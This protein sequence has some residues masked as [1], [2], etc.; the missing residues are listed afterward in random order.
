MA[1]S[2]EHDDFVERLR[3]LRTDPVF[4]PL[5]KG[6]ALNLQPLTEKQIGKIITDKN[7]AGFYLLMAAAQLSRTKLKALMA[8]PSFQVAPKALRKAYALKSRLPR[9]CSFD[10]VVAA[11]SSLRVPDI[12]RKASG[13]VERILRER[14]EEERVP[15]LMSPPIR[16]VPGI[17]TPRERK[18][19]GVYP[20]P[21]SNLPPKL[22]LEIKGIKRV[23]D[24]IQKRLYEIAEV[25]LEMKTLYGNLRLAGLNLASTEGVLGNVAH[26]QKIRSQI[27]AS[28]PVVVAILICPAAEAQRYRDGAE[29]FVDRIF[30]QEEIEDC[31]TF[32]KETCARLAVP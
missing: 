20:D 15:I 21:A 30:F 8:E 12:D 26:R 5:L 29:T 22:Y 24:D 1:A 13:D 7:D 31:I 32:L 3:G 19:D 25:S 23:S 9:S 17:L 10:S 16:R 6:G 27:T 14:L 28:S 11:A 2:P 4:R 18:P